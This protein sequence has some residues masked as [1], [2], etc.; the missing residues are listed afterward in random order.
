M[1]LLILYKIMEMVFLTAHK[2]NIFCK[3]ID[4]HLQAR[5]EKVYNEF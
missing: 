5:M 3:I 1:N 4:R 2:I